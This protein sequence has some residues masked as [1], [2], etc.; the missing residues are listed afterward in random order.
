MGSIEHNK[1]NYEGAID[2]FNEAIE[3]DSEYAP[4][5]LNRGLTFELQG[6]LDEACADWSKASELGLEQA[7]I[8]LKECNEE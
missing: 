6:K 2:W 4:A 5:I 1:G 3:I 7:N 8:Y